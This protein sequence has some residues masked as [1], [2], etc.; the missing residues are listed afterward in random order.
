MYTF[1]WYLHLVLYFMIV[2]EFVLPARLSLAN[3]LSYATQRI[4]DS[5]TTPTHIGN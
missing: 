4:A 1:L 2:L 3:L 5:Q